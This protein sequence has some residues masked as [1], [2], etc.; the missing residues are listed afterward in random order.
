MDQLLFESPSQ[1]AAVASAARDRLYT[2]SLWLTIS[3]SA[4]RALEE[5]CIRDSCK[6]AQVFKSQR[7]ARPCAVLGHVFTV[8]L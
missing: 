2:A 7:L 1:N 3:G 6:T 8:L 4:A 5:M